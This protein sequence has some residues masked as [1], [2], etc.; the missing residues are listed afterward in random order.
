M[1]TVTKKFLN[2]RSVLRA[3]L[4]R[5]KKIAAVGRIRSWLEDENPTMRYPVSCTMISVEDT[6][7]GRNGIEYS[8]EYVSH[9]LRYAAGVAVDLSKLRPAGS[10]NGNGLIAS[11]PVSFMKIYSMLN[12]VLRRGGRFRNGAVTVYLDAFHPDA[13]QFIDFPVQELPWAKKALYVNDN[14]DSPEYILNNPLLPK[15]LAAVANGTL[16]L[17]KKRWQH[18]TLGVVNFA[19]N[20]EDVWENRLFTQVCMEILF[21]SN[22]TC[23]LAHVNLGQCM[24]GDIV[25]A[26]KN[27]TRF[28]AKLHSITGIDKRDYF[29][30]PKFDRQIG[31]GVIGLAN[32]LSYYR[33]KYKDFVE[34]LDA[35]LSYKAEFKEYP[36]TLRLLVEKLYEGYQEAAKIAEEYNLERAFT[37]APTATCS[38][39]HTD[40]R[41]YTTSPEISP[42]ICHVETKRTRRESG[43]MGVTEYQ[44]PI[45]VE[46]AEE[47]GWDT[48][49]RLT[50]VWQRLMNSTGKAHC[51]SINIWTD[52]PCDEAWFKD[53]LTS[54]RITTYYR[55]LAVQNFVDKS[56]IDSGGTAILDEEKEAGFYIQPQQI[57]SEVVDT[58]E[59]FLKQIQSSSNLVSEPPKACDIS[60][61]GEC[62]SCAE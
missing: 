40:K 2:Q 7:E 55:M 3:T 8:W 48:Y 22:A 10:D 42:P 5:D 25:Q 44:Y 26:F 49:W 19:P 17:S 39:N 6:M 50:N 20:P 54:A 56:S 47:V 21:R 57:S 38:F 59:D 31:V 12:G 35:F 4:E 23:L 58:F 36:H 16:W 28:A 11:G 45:N 53:W 30:K 60:N 29:L 61:P 51:M 18:P 34:A 15:I 13:E 41:G 14:P 62:A 52:C 9:C 24:I 27:T 43:T 33:I 46:S 32:L 37:I 1:T